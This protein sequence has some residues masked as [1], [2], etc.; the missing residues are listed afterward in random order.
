M[1]ETEWAKRGLCRDEDPDLFFPIGH[2][3]PTGEV[4]TEKAKA[5]C[6]G[7]PVLAECRADVLA[8]PPEFGVWA[9]LTP[10]ERRKTRAALALV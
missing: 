3:G 2:H 10:D 5:V 8:N 1:T 7:C 9:A 6:R 4:E